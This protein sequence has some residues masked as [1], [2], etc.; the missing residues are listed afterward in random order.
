MMI[1]D[2]VNF[3]ATKIIRAE[4]KR[5]N[6]LWLHHSWIWTML[7]GGVL[8]AVWNSPR[9]IKGTEEVFTTI[10]HGSRTYLDCV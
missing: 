5:V 1:F 9:V 4:Y 10:A 8:K 6:V 7:F 3:F 2:M